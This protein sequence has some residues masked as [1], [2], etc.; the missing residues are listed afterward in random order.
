MRF[1]W[2]NVQSM[3]TTFADSDWAGCL[4]KARSISGGVISIGEHMIQSWSRQQRVVVLSMA[5][6]ALYAMVAA[7]AEC[8]T[9]LASTA[10]ASFARSADL[11][12]GHGWSSSR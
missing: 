3:M 2:Q 7:S 8:I 1:P 5:E 12:T 6:A 10:R 9:M 11:V 4:Q